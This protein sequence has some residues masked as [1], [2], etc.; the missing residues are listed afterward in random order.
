MEKN[1]THVEHSNHSYGKYIVVW[2]AL[3]TLTAITVVVAGVN[4][5]EVTIAAAIIIASIKSYLVLTVFMHLNVES[6]PFKIFVMVAI[7]FIIVSLVLLFS[8]YSNM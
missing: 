2:M 8:D 7:F 6:K 3:L 1:E 4:L 5:G